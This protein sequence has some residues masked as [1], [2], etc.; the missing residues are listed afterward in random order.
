LK[1]T[2][3][4]RRID[5]LGRIVIPIEIRRSLNIAEKDGLEIYID[6]DTIVLHK[7]RRGCCE[8]DSNVI[9]AS[10]GETQLCEA[11]YGELLSSVNWKAVS[12]GGDGK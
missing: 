5:E 7:Y 2:G 8:C 9:Y 11:C 10:I 1:N 12:G 6:G 3:I 4:V